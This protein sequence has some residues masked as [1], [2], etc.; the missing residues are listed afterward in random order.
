MAL[1]VPPDRS[2]RRQEGRR[3]TGKPEKKST[4]IKVHPHTKDTIDRLW[5][6]QKMPLGDKLDS[7]LAH[8]EELKTKHHGSAG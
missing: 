7:L 2:D 4:T 8:Y 3:K 5:P 1:P 6:Y